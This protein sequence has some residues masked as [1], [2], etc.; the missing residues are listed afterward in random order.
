MTT[1]D[2]QKALKIL[3]ESGAV[4]PDD[5]FTYWITDTPASR[6][7]LAPYIANGS[8]KLIKMER[9]SE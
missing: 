7:Y 9:L 3:K 5:K 6:K 8:I 2:M 4:R 1:E